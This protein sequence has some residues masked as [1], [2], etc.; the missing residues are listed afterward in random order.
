MEGAKPLRL[1]MLLVYIPH[2]HITRNYGVN[3]ESNRIMQWQYNNI[4]TQRGSLEYD[5]G[6]VGVWFESKSSCVV[7]W[8]LHCYIHRAHEM[9]VS[10]WVMF[11]KCFS[12]IIQCSVLGTPTI[13]VTHL[14]SHDSYTTPNMVNTLATLITMNQ[15]SLPYNNYWCWFTNPHFRT[16]EV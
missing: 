10:C 11:M 5:S 13:H 8:A 7:F 9:G 6:L 3:S 16:S 1:R 12:S 15:H 2:L 14:N 4:A